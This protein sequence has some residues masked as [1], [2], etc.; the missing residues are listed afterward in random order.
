MIAHS[1]YAGAL[2][3]CTKLLSGCIHKYK[4]NLCLDLGP[5]PRYLHYICANTPKFKKIE[6]LKLFCSLSISA[7]GYSTYIAMHTIFWER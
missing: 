6:N 1:Q 3:Y 7:K 4:Q 5:L 2:K